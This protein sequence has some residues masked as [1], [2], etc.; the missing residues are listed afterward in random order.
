MSQCPSSSWI[1]LILSQL[2]SNFVAY[3][4]LSECTVTLFHKF[5]SSL[6][7]FTL[8]HTVFFLNGFQS[9]LQIFRDVKIK[10]EWITVLPVHGVGFALSSKYSSRSSSLEF[11]KNTRLVFLHFHVILV[12]LLLTCWTVSQRISDNLSQLV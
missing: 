11:A 5:S 7:F 8:S 1:S 9:C 6:Y 2:S 4:C 3:E 10:S 12:S